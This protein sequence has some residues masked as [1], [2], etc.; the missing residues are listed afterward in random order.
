M[1]SEGIFVKKV[2]KN[3]Y[4]RLKSAAAEK[5]VPVYALL[6]EAIATYVEGQKNNKPQGT[7]L[8]LEQVDNAAY[9][10]I[11]SEG[12]LKG[13]WVAIANG[14]LIG[15]AATEEGTV[16]LMRQAYRHRPFKHGILTRVGEPREEGEWLA[17]SLQQG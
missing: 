17:G 16:Q 2:D 7:A 12:A 5:G 15:E 4:R 11:E 14:K 9:S 10:A 13:R 1:A 6:N 8:S 3:M